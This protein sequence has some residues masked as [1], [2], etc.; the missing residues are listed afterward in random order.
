MRRLALAVVMLVAL[1]TPMLAQDA[2]PAF[3]EGVAAVKITQ[4]ASSTNQRF[5]VDA[6][7]QPFFWFGDTVWPLV[8]RP[9]RTEISM[10]LDD[11]A[12]RGFNVI[13]FTGVPA[14]DVPWNLCFN[15]IQG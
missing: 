14:I 13:Q 3:S 5:L 8:Y 6:A 12:S 10:Y 15:R 1:T 4:L 2:V 7:G 9:S 11:R